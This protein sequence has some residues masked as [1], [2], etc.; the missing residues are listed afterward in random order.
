MRPSKD[1]GA[2]LLFIQEEGTLSLH[3]PPSVLSTWM[4]IIQPAGSIWSCDITAES[5]D[6][7]G[8]ERRDDVRTQARVPRHPI[9]FHTHAAYK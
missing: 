5:G 1:G 7:S 8:E 4:T 6:D 9:F 2:I 3:L